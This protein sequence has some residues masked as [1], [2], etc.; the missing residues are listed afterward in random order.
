VEKLK[1]ASGILPTVIFGSPRPGDVRDS[2]ADFNAAR[3]GFNFVPTVGL[4]EGLVE[5]MAWAKA[6]V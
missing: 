4:D 5:Y 2:L 6:Q 1:R 3:R